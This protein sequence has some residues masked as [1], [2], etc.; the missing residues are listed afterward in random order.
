MEREVNNFTIMYETFSH[1]KYSSSFAEKRK[2]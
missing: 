1:S 2:I